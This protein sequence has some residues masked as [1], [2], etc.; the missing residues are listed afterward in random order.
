M[1]VTSSKTVDFPSLGWGIN[2]GEEKELPEDEDAQEAILE[3]DFITEADD[4]SS[5]GSSTSSYS[6][7]STSS[8]SDSDSSDSD[9]EDDE[10]EDDESDE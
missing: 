3:R 6:S 4:D 2:A 1:E 5:T 7:S 9:D 8:T 10:D